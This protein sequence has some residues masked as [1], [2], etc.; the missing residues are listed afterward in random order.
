MTIAARGGNSRDGRKKLREAWV[1]VTT[2]RV[3]PMRPRSPR[4]AAAAEIPKTGAFVSLVRL[5]RAAAVFPDGNGY[6]VAV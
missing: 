6:S 5:R 3:F 4:F 1:C 2:R